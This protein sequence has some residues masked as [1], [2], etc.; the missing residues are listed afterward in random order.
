[1]LLEWQITLTATIAIITTDMPRGL[2]RNGLVKQGVKHP[3]Q[4]QPSSQLEQALAREVFTQQP[5]QVDAC[6]I[7]ERAAERFFDSQ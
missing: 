2:V 5:D 3:E 7:D 4:Q 1:M 6:Q